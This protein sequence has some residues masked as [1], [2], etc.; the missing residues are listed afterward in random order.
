MAS[1]LRGTRS[2]I[3]S[4][5]YTAQY[6][7]YPHATPK[8][9]ANRNVLTAHS[10]ECSITLEIYLIWNT[11]NENS[12]W[13]ECQIRLFPEHTD[14]SSVA[15]HIEKRKLKKHSNIRQLNTEILQVF[16]HRNDHNDDNPLG[17]WENS[18][19]L[20]TRKVMIINLAD[21]VILLRS[22]MCARI[23]VMH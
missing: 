5:T 17:K 23:K 6:M 13:E 22:E 8:D 10:Q 3:L 4:A 16:S 21:C 1:L 9:M 20:T 11:F 12:L 19:G 14:N 15:K 18:D 2:I 7:I